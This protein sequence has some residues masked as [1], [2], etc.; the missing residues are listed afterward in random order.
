MSRRVIYVVRSWPRLSQTFVVNEILALEQRGVQ[1]TIVALARAREDLVQPEVA[2]VRARVHYLD[3]DGPD[4]DEQRVLT[5][6][7]GTVGDHLR[8]AAAGPGR[9]LA[10]LRFAR[11]HPELAAGYATC[12]SAQAFGHA[13]RVAALIARSRPHHTNE[14]GD[15]IGHIHAHFAHDPALVGMLAR[16]L[17]GLP[18]SFTA[19][20]RDLYQIPP[21]SVVSRAGEAVAVVTCCQ[22]NASYLDEVLAGAA[23]L[24]GSVPPVHVVHH[25]V[26]LDRF[27]PTRDDAAGPPTRPVVVSVGRL[28]EKKGYADLLQACARVRAAGRDLHLRIIG[29]G[30]LAAELRTLAG[31]LDLGE[32]VVFEGEKDRDEV[33]GALRG[34]Q[35]F[36]L[37]PREL[38]DG[39]RD[40]IPN[41]FVEAMACGLPVVATAAGGVTE[42]VRHEVNG[43]VAAPGDVA[44]VAAHLE[45]LL[46]DEGLRTRLGTAARHTV[47]TD[48]DVAA[49]AATLEAI[50]GGQS[51]GGQIRRAGVAAVSQ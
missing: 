13:V 1:L 19:H 43:L 29:D 2:R 4:G 41:V 36:A 34:A 12:T 22:V 18:F 3:G 50:F 10:A 15:G 23:V 42:L 5:R 8:V 27:T 35:V 46:G 20:A 14:D 11:A 7:R 9:Y 45:A 40:G 17:T 37:T 16:R 6:L 30:P 32:S 24:A 48:Y 51:F 21:E 49:A 44:A 25:G 31:S 33:L 39:D 47:E 38:A 26:E 28:V